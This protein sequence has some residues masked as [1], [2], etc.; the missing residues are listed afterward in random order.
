MYQ[1]AQITAASSDNCPTKKMYFPSKTFSHA[2]FLAYGQLHLC[3]VTESISHHLTSIF[4]SEVVQPPCSHVDNSSWR[5]QY[6]G[7]SQY[8]EKI[9][10][11]HME[12][13][14]IVFACLVMTP[15]MMIDLHSIAKLVAKEGAW[16]NRCKERSCFWQKVDRHSDFCH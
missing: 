15:T 6:D 12:P 10:L 7:H 8:C 16:V 4:Q 2:I 1:E 13:L 9:L 14:K 5:C 11:L 3:S